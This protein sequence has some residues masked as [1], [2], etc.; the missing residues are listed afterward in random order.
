M[1]VE[2]RRVAVVFDRSVLELLE[3]VIPFW[4]T[5]MQHDENV[6]RV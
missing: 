5:A 3:L 1:K 4:V 2:E 6:V